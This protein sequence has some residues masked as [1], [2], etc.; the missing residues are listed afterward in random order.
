MN[1]LLLEPGEI[2]NDGTVCL[3]DRR[4]EHIAK[5]LG[6]KPGEMIRAGIINGPLGTAEILGVSGKGK[7][8]K[9]LLRFTSHGIL[10]PQSSIDLVLGLIR[11][12]MLKRVL[13]QATSLGVGRIFLIN[14][15]RVEKSFFEA[16]LLKAENFRSYLLHGLEQA[17]DTRLPI[18]SIHRRFKPF[19]E[20]F[21]PGTAPDYDLMLVA[22]P[23][24]MS[25][26][27]KIINTGRK[28]RT[29]LAVG[30][31]GGWLDF[32]L[33]KFL[34]YSFIQVSLGSRILRT[35]TAVVALL[36]Q[37]LLMENETAGR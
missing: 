33:E 34:Q 12:I 10:P 2:D 9:V 8:A 29:L 5:V 1:L 18:V 25:N 4:S 37:L 11:P 27:R 23:D 13:S 15:G 17:G 28:K 3:Q 31:E 16:S 6:S 14:A 20:D 21:I 36:A 7:R 19:I 26:L 22:H 32:E 30:P 35:D 24:K